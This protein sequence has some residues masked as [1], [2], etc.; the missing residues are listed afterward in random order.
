MPFVPSVPGQGVA[1]QV[2]SGGGL[3]PTEPGATARLYVCGIT[4]YDATHLGHAAT[5]VTFDL[6]HRV[7]RDNGHTVHYVQN[8]TDIDDP[9]LER[10]A[11]DGV[12]WRDLAHSE[13]ALF[14]EDMTAL[15]VLP[16]ADYVGVVESIE[17]IAADVR[18][19]VES[20]AAY[21]VPVP[22]ADG[23]DPGAHDVYF[24]LASDPRFGEVSGWSRETMLEVFAERGGDPL[25]EGK[26][27]PLD[28]LMWRARRPNEPSWDG[29]SVG[30]GRPGW[31]GECTT[32]AL[33]HLGMSFDVQGGGTDLVFP[34]H[35]MSAAQ[36][37]GLT[38]QWPFA[39]AYVHQAM[40][41]LDGEKMSKSKGNLVKV[42]ALRAAGHDP[43]A[44]RLVLLAHHYRTEWSYTDQALVTATARLERWRAALSRQGGPAAGP[45]LALIRERLSDDLD[46]PGALA[47]VDA[48]AD[49]Q[50]A[51]GDGGS[52]ID[53]GID[54][55]GDRAEADLG[56]PGVIGRAL[57]ALL[58]VRV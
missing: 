15:A 55:D 13:I 30:P 46:A 33:Q 16:P 1:L 56:A 29:G 34:H 35:E 3:R 31:H 23:A 11:R 57:D 2:H 48:W 12:D 19:L 14:H 21:L 36:A 42:S 26:R 53:G 17:P 20:G 24:D 44:I 51:R 5:Y 38:G 54:G 22:P 40:V 8:V 9:L 49:V 50:L 37:Q 45:T 43:M 4:P 10:A 25:R 52:G 18:A 41:G 28:P 7:W 39:Q 58:G 47:A 32:I 6:L 27:S